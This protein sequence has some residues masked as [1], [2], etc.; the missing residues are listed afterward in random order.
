MGLQDVRCS[1]DG[2]GE[3]GG[4]SRH[5]TAH[6]IDDG[7]SSTDDAGNGSSGRR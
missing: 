1:R 2:S 6:L 4:A 3:C 5:F 7:K